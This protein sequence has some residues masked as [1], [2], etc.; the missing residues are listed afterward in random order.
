MLGCSPRRNI[1][2]ETVHQEDAI[3]ENRRNPNSSQFHDEI[4]FPKGAQEKY[5]EEEND[6]LVLDRELREN[7]LIDT[8]VIVRTR[9]MQNEL[10]HRIKNLVD[11]K[12]VNYGCYKQL[13]CTGTS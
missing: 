12:E 9:L 1:I 6:C 3:D 10:D 8:A 2:D 7:D 5:R 11:E 4:K 13:K